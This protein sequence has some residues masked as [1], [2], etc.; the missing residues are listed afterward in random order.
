[1]RMSI[2]ITHVVEGREATAGDQDATAVQ[3]PEQFK[4]TEASN[5]LEY[6]SQQC[7]LKVGIKR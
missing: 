3:E 2:G 5:E 4:R 1:M 7:V 6:D